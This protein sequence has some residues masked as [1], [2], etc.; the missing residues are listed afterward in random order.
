MYLQLVTKGLVTNAVP[1]NV[2]VCYETCLKSNAKAQLI[3]LLP[4]T[5]NTGV[6]NQQMV[7]FSQWSS[8]FWVDTCVYCSKHLKYKIINPMDGSDFKDERVSLDSANNL[9]VSTESNFRTRQTP[10]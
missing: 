8:N 6:K 2:I 10:L 5:S 1:F 4:F 7:K 3:F 9:L